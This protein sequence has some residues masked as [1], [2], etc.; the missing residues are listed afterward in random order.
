[1]IYRAT[2][3]LTL[4]LALVFYGIELLMGY[5]YFSSDVTVKG[6]DRTDYLL[7]VTTA[8]LIMA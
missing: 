5:I 4:A 3:C 2:G 8:S 7:L 6:W 1:M